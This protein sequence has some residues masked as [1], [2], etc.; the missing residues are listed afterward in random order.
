[1][2]EDQMKEWVVAAEKLRTEHPEEYAAIV[3]RNEVRWAKC[4]YDHSMPLTTCSK[5][6]FT[7]FNRS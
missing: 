4:P 2:T 1:M 5:C 3:A 6:G 7:N